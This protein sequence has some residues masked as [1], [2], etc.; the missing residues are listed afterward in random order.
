MNTVDA[1]GQSC[2]IPV[3]MTKDAVEKELPVTVLVDDMTPVKNITRF[4]ASR[5]LSM[6]YSKTADGDYVIVLTK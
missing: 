4:A 3:I 6:D 1:R 5:G 2:P